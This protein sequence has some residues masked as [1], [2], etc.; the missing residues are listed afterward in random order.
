MSSAEIAAEL[1]ISRERAEEIEN[2]LLK[3]GLIVEEE[4]VL[5]MGP[6]TTFVPADSHWSTRHHLNWRTKNLNRIEHVTKEELCFTA[7]LSCSADDFKKIK[8]S[9]LEL[10]KGT[11]ATVSKTTPENVYTLCIDLLKL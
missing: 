10:I 11:R 1:K 5:R 9:V 4:G 2:F 6:S 8:E 7:P 3:T